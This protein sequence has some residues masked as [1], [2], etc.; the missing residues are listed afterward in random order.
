MKPAKKVLGLTGPHLL[1]TLQ[2]VV[3]LLLRI[4]TTRMPSIHLLLSQ[5]VVH[6][7]DGA[8]RSKP[9]LSRDHDMVT[10]F[11]L[12]HIMLEGWDGGGK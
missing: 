4:A 6:L 8:D 5:C 9:L 10:H 2:L 11:H 7:G 1:W 3:L 12:T